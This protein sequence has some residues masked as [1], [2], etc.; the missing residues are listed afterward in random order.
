[1]TN[2]DPEEERGKS[3][4]KGKRKASHRMN[5]NKEGYMFK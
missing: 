5:L 3:Q 2:Q 4:Q 1:M